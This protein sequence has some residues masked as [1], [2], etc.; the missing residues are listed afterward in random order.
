MIKFL[1]QV[2]EHSDEC[3]ANSAGRV[4]PRDIW[5]YNCTDNWVICSAI[6]SRG[7]LF[8]ALTV[9]SSAET[10]VRASKCLSKRNGCSRW[11]SI[12][13]KFKS[14]HMLLDK[15]ILYEATSSRARR[16]ERIHDQYIF[17][18]SSAQDGCAAEDAIFCAR[19][20]ETSPLHTAF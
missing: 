7:V 6:G 10:I 9:S 14:G 12:Y 15:L 3:L 19:D 5:S 4:S 11:P 13:Q 18:A 17:V 20:S 2:R 8:W 16:H 1:L